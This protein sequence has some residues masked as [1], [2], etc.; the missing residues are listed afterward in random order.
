MFGEWVG[1]ELIKVIS[2]GKYY[3]KTAYHVLGLICRSIYTHTC[4][5][6]QEVHPVLCAKASKEGK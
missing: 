4:K 1:H 5:P 6:K 2:L 3:L